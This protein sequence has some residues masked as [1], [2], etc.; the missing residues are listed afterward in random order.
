M[1]LI[2]RNIG[3]SVKINVEINLVAAKPELDLIA[4]RVFNNRRLAATDP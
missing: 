3:R 4:G 2:R 1:K